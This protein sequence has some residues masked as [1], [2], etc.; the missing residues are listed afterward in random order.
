MFSSTAIR[1]LS[2]RGVALSRTKLRPS[3]QVQSI[4]RRHESTTFY[5]VDVAGLTED[6]AEVRICD[7]KV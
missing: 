5:N 2:R 3:F 6:Q 4:Q 7:M 1:A